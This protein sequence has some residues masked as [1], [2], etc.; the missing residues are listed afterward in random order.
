[1]PK[2][3]NDVVVG[4]DV[5]ADFSYATILNPDGDIAVKSFKFVNHD[6]ESLNKLLDKIKEVEKLYSTTA[7]VVMESTGI[8]HMPLSHFLADK[9]LEVFILNPLITNSTKNEDIRKVKSDKRDALKIAELVR[10]RDVKLSKPVS[11]DV[12]RLRSLCRQHYNLVDNRSTLK[13]RLGTQLRLT[14]PGYHTIFSDLTSSTSITILRTYGG[15]QGILQA[16]RDEIVTL[17]SRCARK[18]LRWSEDK[19]DTLVR[20]AEFAAVLAV[21]YPFED[22]IEPLLV[23][24]ELLSQ[25]I[26]SSIRRMQECLKQLPTKL[27]NN[28]DLITS[29]PGVGLVTALTIIAEIGDFDAFS[30]PKQLVAFFGVDPG[31][32]ESGKFRGDRNTMS[33]RGTR[34]GRRALYTLALQSVKTTRNGIEM[35]PIIREYFQSKCK[36]KK[37]KVALVAVMHKLINYIFAILRDQQPYEMRKPSRHEALHMGKKQHL[38]SV[39]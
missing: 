20:V 30:K 23:Q 17:I 7:K 34:T 2:F 33:K 21:P 16:S 19:A 38:Q 35:N 39:A 36:S 28:I 26:D 8:Y 13:L 5:A 32:N 29:L 10:S 9:G 3:T 37:K 18:G 1:L 31:V 11:K 14:F 6:L 24:I 4:I 22:V 25:Q 12:L 15:P 27:A